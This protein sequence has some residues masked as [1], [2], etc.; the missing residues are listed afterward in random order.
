MKVLFVD[1]QYDYGVKSRGIN[2]IG[3]M[4]F[5][6]AFE[7]LG[8]ETIPF[9]YDE[10]LENNSQQ[11]QSDLLQK[12][13]EVQPDLIFFCLF[14]DQFKPA[15][16]EKLN[17]KY[18]TMNWFGDDAWRFDNFTKFFAP[19]FTYSVTTDKFSLKK[20]KAIGINQVVHAQW[21]AIDDDRSFEKK[22]YKYDVSFI[23]GANPY[24]KWFVKNLE[25]M[26]VKIHCF[27]NG[28]PNGPLSNDEMIEL[29]QTS[30][31]NLNISNSAC[32]DIRYLFAH[33][34]NL[35]HT[36][37]SKKQSSQTKARNFEINYYGGF[38]LTDYVPAIEDYYEIGKEI[39]CYTYPEEASVQIKYFLEHDKERESIRERGESKAK[40]GYTYTGQ[41]RKVLSEFG[42]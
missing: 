24:R 4:G 42:L 27:G 3:I 29:F 36:L 38:Q 21:A 25:K 14:R 13:D 1:M 23:G 11:L 10:Y 30:K 18:K 9:Y 2:A 40:Q 33:P 5:K 16:L 28:W 17:A 15:T 35:A 7:N 31:I 12:A 22:P 32:Y 6:K 34:K 41:I 19:H 37:V 20:Y 39:A 8:H 26:G